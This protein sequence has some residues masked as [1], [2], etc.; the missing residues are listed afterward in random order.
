MSASDLITSPFTKQPSQLLFALVVCLV[1]VLIGVLAFGIGGHFVAN[2]GVGAGAWGAVHLGPPG[3]R[4]GLVRI[5]GSNHEAMTPLPSY[6]RPIPRQMRRSTGAGIWDTSGGQYGMGG[7]HRTIMGYEDK[8][9]HGINR[10]R[11]LSTV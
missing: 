7:S 4:E 6:R 3:A 11:P 9:I 2:K 5:A 10:A 1:L 8:Y